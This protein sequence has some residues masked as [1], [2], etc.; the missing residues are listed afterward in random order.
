MI[1]R[2]HLNPFVNYHELGD[3]VVRDGIGGVQRISTSDAVQ[4]EMLDRGVS[5]LNLSARA[6]NCL[7]AA[8][9]LTLRD[10]VSKSEA[11]LLRVRSFGKTS[12][13]EVQRRLS[14]VGLSLGMR[15]EGAEGMPP[16][17]GE[18]GSE[19]PGP[20]EVFTMGE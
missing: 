2:K 20:M 18:G 17:T 3:A 19:Q 16:A 6:S 9:V 1:L 7:E 15:V 11:D 10:L 12:L 8:R 4:A 13:H 14:E 5:S